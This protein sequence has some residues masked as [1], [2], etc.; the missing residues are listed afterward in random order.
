MGVD[1][2]GNLGN[3]ILQQIQ[4]EFKLN[5]KGLSTTECQTNENDTSSNQSKAIPTNKSDDIS[6][7]NK[8]QTNKMQ[9]ANTTSNRK[10]L[11]SDTLLIL[12]SAN[13]S[14]MLDKEKKQLNDDIHFDIEDNHIDDLIASTSN[15]DDSNLSLSAM[16]TSQRASSNSK[17]ST[18]SKTSK[19]IKMFQPTLNKPSS[20]SMG[21]AILFF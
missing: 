5:S 11:S 12:N 7:T 18:K 8:R 10:S 14:F 19:L 9:N 17:M 1:S 13:V 15:L 3:N 21:N 2:N 6:L 4:K 16:N 20:S